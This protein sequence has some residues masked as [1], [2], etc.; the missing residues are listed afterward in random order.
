[1]LAA[2]LAWSIVPL[3]FARSGGIESPFLFNAA[4]RLGIAVSG[5]LIFWVFFRPIILN[6]LV[7]TTIRRHLLRWAMLLAVLNSFQYALFSWATRFIDVSIA[8]V[9]LE[10]WPI[11]VILFMARLLTAQR[12]YRKNITSILPLLAVAFA[13]LG[14]VV[15]S[16]AGGF[17]IGG[18]SASTMIKGFSLALAAAIVGALDAVTF[19][20]G[21]DVADQLQKD[22]MIADTFDLGNLTLFGSIVA[23]AI[24]SIPGT[25]I[26]SGI[27]IA[28][29]ET[30]SLGVVVI[31]V[32]GG[33]ILHGTGNFLFRRANL[34]TTNLGVN[35]LGYLTPAI[36]LILLAIF[37]EINVAKPSY[38]VI[39]TAAIVA[40]NL[41]INF[42]AERLLGFKALVVSLWVCG[43]LVFMRSVGQ[44][45]W[46]AKSDG[47]FD[48]LF[49]SATVF[50][51]ILSF[52]T[53]RLASRT[54][55]EGKLAFK[56][57]RE[58]EELQRL[59]VVD[60]TSRIRQH[61]IDMDQKQGQ[62]LEDA[63]GN[64]RHIISKSLDRAVGTEREKLKELEVDLDTLAH[65]RQQ[66]INFGE[67]CALCIFAILVVGTALLSRPAEV[68]G[69]T[70]FLV[71]MFAMLFP[72]V[73]LFLTFNVFDL[74][75][76]RVSRILEEDPKYAGYGVAFHDTVHQS[77]TVIHSNRRVV[78]QWIS[79][80]VG[81]LLIVAYS[82]LFLNKWGLLLLN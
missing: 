26:S 34:N 53:A 69:V 12:G 77:A 58:L 79:I 78:E 51:L 44:W 8:A 39:G 62:D 1:M 29:G 67:L 42:E 28:R 17:Q 43:T 13:G 27:G 10:L 54:Q 32:A 30:I 46:T 21:Q 40:S 22:G 19:R 65:S 57:F 76:D 82:A 68:S 50:A 14:F 64:A 75:R 48:V 7:W 72:A 31:G 3:V 4:W 70:G 59:D 60:P 47:Y 56:L 55:D 25:V 5:L 9:L 36:S 20:W 45:G 15:A 81:L 16:Q 2:V 41:L 73:I 49:L 38:L 71:E 80:G 35:A 66:G 11:M 18:N 24:T 52:R 33:V 6:R 74:Q 63:Y 23:Y 61:V 37:Y